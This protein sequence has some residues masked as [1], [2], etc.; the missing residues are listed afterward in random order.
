METVLTLLRACGKT[1]VRLEKYVPGYIINRMQILLNTEVFYLLEKWYLH[2][3][4]LDLAVKA[5]LMPRGMVL[6]LCSAI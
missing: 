4:Q 6:G 2:S 5:S 1:P 3:E